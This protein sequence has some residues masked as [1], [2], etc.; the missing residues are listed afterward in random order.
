[1]SWWLWARVRVAH[2]LLDRSQ[3]HASRHERRP[4]R[5]AHV[6]EPD[7]PD[8]RSLARRLEAARDLRAIQRHAQLGV[9]E[10][11]VVIVGEHGAQPP[12]LQLES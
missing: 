6:V 10:D 9:S 5:V 11:Q 7:L 1:M 4:E 12:L 2:V 3:R 8:P